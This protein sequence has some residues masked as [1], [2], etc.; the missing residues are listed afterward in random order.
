MAGEDEPGMKRLV[1]YVV[2]REGESPAEDRGTELKQSLADFMVPSAF[3]GL[4]QFPLTPNGKIDRKAL[5]TPEYKKDA[6]ES[7][8]APRTPTEE[9]VAS[10]WAEVLH[11]G[12]VSAAGDFF[13]LGG[14]SL[15]AAQVISRLRQAFAVEI[16]L[17]AMVYSPKPGIL[18]T[19]SQ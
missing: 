15:L 14:H 17:K 12:Q 6:G 11:L 2:A 7:Y 8:I 18:S 4:K 13:A 1:A 16:P 9:R 19:R 3:V 10:I 5:P